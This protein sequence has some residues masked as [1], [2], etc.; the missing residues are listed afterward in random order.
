MQIFNVLVVSL[1]A[2]SLFACEDKKGT[3]EP[4]RSPDRPSVPATPVTAK[5][6]E[7]ERLD[8]GEVERLVKQ[9]LNA[10]NQGDFEK[11]ISLYAEEMIGIKRVGD[12][13]SE[14][15][16][17]GWE[18]DRRRMFQK[19][20]DVQISQVDV[21]IGQHIGVVDFIQGFESAGFKDTGPKRL[22]V[23]N[24]NSGPKIIREEMIRSRVEQAGL[25][26][27]SGLQ[28][29]QVIADKYVVISTETDDS[30]AK[31]D[32]RVADGILAF[33]SVAVNR[34]PEN[35]RS[36]EGVNFKVH[37]PQGTT[38]ERKVSYVRLIA[39]AG[40]PSGEAALIMS[41]R[42]K[43]GAEDLYEM[44]G[45][46]GLVLAAELKEPCIGGV[47]AT[48][49][50]GSVEAVGTFEGLD[51]IPEEVL[52]AFRSDPMWQKTQQEFEAL[53]QT[54]FW[55]GGPE[56]FVT[57]LG[58]Q[59]YIALQAEAGQGC[60][61]FRGAMFALYHMRGNDPRVLTVGEDAQ[62]IFRPV[63]AATFSE[64]DGP[65]FYSREK[66]LAKKESKWSV[67]QDL[68]PPSYVCPC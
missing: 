49:V 18:K 53:G 63:M 5:S 58:E 38:C 46:Q 2:V 31:G 30:W 6:A 62:G 26:P 42:P 54:G 15:D 41:E 47:F 64:A 10:Q 48:A 22:V 51:D 1:L 35:L 55:D 20:M 17:E 57:Q 27:M 32:A 50:T 21:R 13:K 23:E 44:A 61:E 14:F 7:F 24:T 28:A 52:L 43:K 3:P 45:W 8:R 11:Y 12:Q 4:D 16:R 67:V 33:K 40:L 36:Y 34:L 29:G 56:A 60:G 9:W 59:R 66:V 65:I 19:E 37:T 68:T 39:R 25:E